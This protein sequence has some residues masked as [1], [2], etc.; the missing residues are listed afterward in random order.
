[1]LHVTPWTHLLLSELWHWDSLVQTNH[2]CIKLKNQIILDLN[3]SRVWCVF[4]SYCV[5]AQTR[6]WSHFIYRMILLFICIPKREQQLPWV[7]RLYVFSW[8]VKTKWAIWKT[9]V[10]M[11][12]NKLHKY[13]H[14]PDCPL[15]A[16]AHVFWTDQL[17]KHFLIQNPFFW[18]PPTTIAQ[19]TKRWWVPWK[20]LASQKRRLTQFIR[21]WR[22]FFCW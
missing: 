15:W 18:R 17:A 21:S 3:L 22:P 8:R 10:D 19:A 7:C 14:N 4:H 6:C 20:W 5:E 2:H 13:I 11:K 16:S 1:M 12:W 9:A